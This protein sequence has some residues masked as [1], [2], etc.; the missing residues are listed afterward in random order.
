[1]QK[2]I[3][4]KYLDR[5]N[6]NDSLTDLEID[7]VESHIQDCGFCDE[8][9]KRL[10]KGVKLPG[11][12]G[13]DLKRSIHGF[14]ILEKL[15]SG[16]FATV[17]RAWENELKRWVALKVFEETDADYESLGSNE[18]TITANLEGCSNTVKIYGIKSSPLCI[19]QE[20]IGGDS[21]EDRLEQSTS[22]GPELPWEHVLD[23]AI[24]IAHALVDLHRAGINHC[25]LKPANVLLRKDGTA[26]LADFGAAVDRTSPSA[27]RMAEFGSLPYMSPEGLKDP[28]AASLPKSDLYSLGVVIYQLLTNQL[29]YD[30]ESTSD[31]ADQ[32]EAG[33][34][35]HPSSVRPKVPRGLEKLCLQLMNPKA[36]Q[37]P[38]NA[39]Q[40]RLQ[41]IGLKFWL[42]FR[43]HAVVT[44]VLAALVLATVGYAL[45]RNQADTEKNQITLNPE[46]ETPEPQVDSSD[47]SQEDTKAETTPRMGTRD[48]GSEAENVAMSSGGEENNEGMKKAATL[49]TEHAQEV[50]DL[51][52]PYTGPKVLRTL[53]EGGH[54]DPSVL[55]LSDDVLSLT[56]QQEKLVLDVSKKVLQ[57]V[58]GV[59]DCHRKVWNRMSQVLNFFLNEKLQERVTAGVFV[60]PTLRK[61]AA[62]KFFDRTPPKLDPSIEGDL[63]RDPRR[64]SGHT[65]NSIPRRVVGLQV[66][67]S[68]IFYLLAMY[69]VANHSHHQ[70]LA[71]EGEFDRLL[72]LIP[73]SKLTSRKDYS[74]ITYTNVYG[75]QVDVETRGHV[76]LPRKYQDDFAAAH[77]SY[78]VKED[79][80]TTYRPQKQGLG[81]AEGLFKERATAPPK[82]FDTKEN[83]PLNRDDLRKLRGTLENQMLPL[84]ELLDQTWLKLLPMNAVSVQPDGEDTYFTQRVLMEE[85]DAL[86]VEK[87]RSAFRTLL[88]QVSKSDTTDTAVS[89]TQVYLSPEQA[90]D[91][92]QLVSKSPQLV[93]ADLAE[94]LPEDLPDPLPAVFK[95]IESSQKDRFFSAPI[96]AELVESVD[97]FSKGEHLLKDGNDDRAMELIL[98][99]VKTT[100]LS[101]ARRKYISWLCG[102]NLANP[103]KGKKLLGLE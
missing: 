95:A 29:P 83:G 18:A 36:D 15:G 26:V 81:L 27:R 68:D 12:R 53:H 97:L 66:K 74:T 96:P 77:G 88:D 23:W 75:K 24:D 33:N 52:K 60:H 17:Y 28:A 65:V 21:L 50:P 22:V 41:L 90:K 5:Y 72:G 46:T 79:P 94:A 35:A 63:L 100:Q 6:K 103:E 19:V 48:Q 10:R 69:R 13:V 89:L 1:M 4:L 30:G 78:Y 61:A 85:I 70:M 71:E 80:L 67:K 32:I 7:R 82:E 2:H 98:D 31:F 39:A 43:T 93:N 92:H 102:V 73:F 56:S 40:T 57:Q 9:R 58:N 86:L 11:M 55:D 37:R 62:E 38:S 49:V 76:Y 20:F 54:L 16:G 51:P 91:F 34:L 59:E 14:L 44:L 47:Q 87:N 25:D 42:R 45:T 64:L 3:S 101:L 84:S 8:N 99:A